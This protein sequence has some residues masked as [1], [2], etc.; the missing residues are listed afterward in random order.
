M[1]VNEAWLSKFLESFAIF[2]PPGDS[3]HSPCLIDNDATMERSKKSFKY[4]SFLSTHPTF[5]E[6][7]V[8]AWAKEVCVCSKLFV[9][10][11]RMKEVKAACKLLNR[12]G[13][14]NLQQ[15]TKDALTS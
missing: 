12:N 2:D 3:D 10:G 14:G 6:K 13:F 5:K 8:E 4:F 1:L 7:M 11:Q 15:R 9:V